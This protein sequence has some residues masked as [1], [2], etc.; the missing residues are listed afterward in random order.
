MNISTFCLLYNGQKCKISLTSFIPLVRSRTSSGLK[1]SSFQSQAPLLSLNQSL[2]DTTTFSS[3][4][5]HNVNTYFRFFSSLLIRR[6]S[7]RCYG[8]CRIAPWCSGRSDVPW[9]WNGSDVFYGE[10]HVRFHEGALSEI[11][12]VFGGIILSSYKPTSPPAVPNPDSVYE[13]MV[14]TKRFLFC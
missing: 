14:S 13:G 2:G 3:Q 12:Q 6:F 11:L 5:V 7:I 9:P 10:A 8:L 1:F 4:V